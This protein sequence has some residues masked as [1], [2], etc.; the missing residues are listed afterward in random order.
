MFLQFDKELMVV[1][2]HIINK[3]QFVEEFLETDIRLKDDSHWGHDIK[4]VIF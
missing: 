1:A 4:W 3:N 2:Q